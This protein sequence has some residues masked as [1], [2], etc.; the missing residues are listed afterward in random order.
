MNSKTICA[1]AAL[2]IGC[3]ARTARFTLVE[4]TGEVAHAD[5]LWQERHVHGLDAVIEALT[6]DDRDV[7]AHPDVHWRMARAV[8]AKGQ[9]AHGREASLDGY[10]EARAIALSC[11][12]ESPAFRLRRAEWGWVDAIEFIPQKRSLCA[13]MLG[14]AWVRWFGEMG[15]ASS[16][17]D[18]E[19]LDA[20]L[21]W[22]GRQQ[23]RRVQE[24]AQWAQ[25]LLDAM[26]SPYDGRD[27]ERSH[28]TFRTLADQR[29]F[30]AVMLEADQLRW[31]CADMGPTYCPDLRESLERR[32]P[33]A[34]DILQAVTDALAET[35]PSS[36]SSGEKPPD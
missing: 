33:Q 1:I 23:Q 18:L 14:L 4:V 25:A 5:R 3:S 28:E 32:D 30:S 27:L 17:S 35:A 13:S 8:I 36:A 11:L 21:G 15:P 24:Y 2:C 7:A 22:G 9:A 26:R 29:E 10:G 19:V 16:S 31:G 34:P 20:L 6:F 12:E